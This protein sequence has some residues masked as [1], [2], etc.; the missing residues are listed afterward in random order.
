[1]KVVYVPDVVNVGGLG[2]EV[3]CLCS[4]SSCECVRRG[5]PTFV[6][7]GLA[8]AKYGVDFGRYI[9]LVQRVSAV[10]DDVYAVVP[11]AFCDAEM[12][13]RNWKRWARHVKRYA[14]TVL[15]LQRFYEDV[16]K[17]SDV[18]Q[19]ADLVALPSRYHCDAY[20]LE[21]P[22]LCAERIGRVVDVLRG[23]DVHL[24][25]PP[26]TVL[27]ALGNVLNDIRSIDTSA[28]RKLGDRIATRKDDKTKYLIAWLG[29]W[30]TSMKTTP[31][32]TS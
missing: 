25:G 13:I 19:E 3:G 27:R 24:M 32:A 31:L 11:D 15:V 2:V 21:R 8:G 29:K 23:V 10:V 12:T 26:A 7:V 1:V 18:I 17:Y 9:R 6:D 22:R 28:Y 20:C 4:L 5:V 30:N 14:K 16:D